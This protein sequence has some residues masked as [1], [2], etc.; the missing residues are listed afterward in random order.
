M[1]TGIR[2]HLSEEET[3][4]IRDGQP[5]APLGNASLVALGDTLERRSVAS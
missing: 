4:C 5:S 1:A 2:N 3:I